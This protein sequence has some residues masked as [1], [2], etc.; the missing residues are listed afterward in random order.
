MRSLLDAAEHVKPLDDWQVLRDAYLTF[1]HT[2]LPAW[3]KE[4]DPDGIYWPVVAIVRYALPQRQRP[5]S[6]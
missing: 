6:G 5:G 2:T 1:F 3:V 4:W